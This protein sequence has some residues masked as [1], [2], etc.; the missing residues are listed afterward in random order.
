[1][2]DKPQP[3]PIET[4]YASIEK[5]YAREVFWTK[6]VPVLKNVGLVIWSVVDLVLVFGTFIFFV[7]YLVQGVFTEKALVTRFVQNQTS[8]REVSANRQ[9]K[10]VVVSNAQVLPGTDGRFDLVGTVSNPNAAWIARFEYYFETA[11]GDTP[12]TQGYALPGRETYVTELSQG[13]GKGR[14]A[15][16]QLHVENITWERVQ[17]IA[18]NDVQEW[19]DD[20]D[21]L[22]IS[23][24][25]HGAVTTIGTRDVVQT[26]F[27]ITNESP[28]SYWD[29][30][31]IL[32]LR[33]GRNIVGVNKVRLPALDS[34]ETTQ[35]TVNWFWSA[36]SGAMPEVVPQ[37]DFFDPEVYKSQ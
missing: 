31:L 32:L 4:E 37:I 11:A 36:S 29:V 6:T 2:P 17:D 20:H 16:A 22:T 21:R 7:V 15:S 13:D 24:L 34:G 8:A 23:D 33:V 12:K 27:T 30:D 26:S 5:Q 3:T 1:M 25:A 18:P 9:A 35:Q 14:P 10:G 19:I 28:Y